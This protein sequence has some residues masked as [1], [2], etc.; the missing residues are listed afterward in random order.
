MGSRYGQP[1][2]IVV[3]SL[4][5][6]ENS[7]K[8]SDRDEFEKGAC[9]GWPELNP[10]LAGTQAILEAVLSPTVRHRGQYPM[11]LRSQSQIKAA[12]PPT[13]SANSLRLPAFEKI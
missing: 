1:F 8:L 13:V 6:K 7:S 10:H 4:S 5:E 2:P 9:G 3:V 11:S 12:L